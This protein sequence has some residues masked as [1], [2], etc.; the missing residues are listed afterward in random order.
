MK[1]FIKNNPTKHCGL[2]FKLDFNPTTLIEIAVYTDVLYS[3]F[4]LL[5]SVIMKKT[6][7]LRIFAQPKSQKEVII[8]TPPS[9]HK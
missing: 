7:K 1:L 4:Q 8:H 9:A 6:Q 3:V 5:V 2:V